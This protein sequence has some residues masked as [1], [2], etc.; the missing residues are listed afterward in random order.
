MPAADDGC[1]AGGAGGFALRK[2]FRNNLLLAAEVFEKLDRPADALLYLAEPLRMDPDDPKTDM[3]PTTHAIGHALRGR[4]LASQGKK[5]EAEA[6][7][8]EAI[9]VSHRTGLR[10]FEMF[11]LRD[12]KKHVLDGDG[13]GESGVRRLK[14]VLQEMHGPVEELTKLLGDGLDAEEILRS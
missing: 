10:L 14:A 9:E 6:A 13:R 12:L 7:F 3:R 11:A 2:H 4:M 8:E 1:S 5:V